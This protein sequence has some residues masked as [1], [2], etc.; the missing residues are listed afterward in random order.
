MGDAPCGGPCMVIHSAH[1]HSKGSENAC[2]REICL[3]QH[4]QKSSPSPR[5]FTFLRIGRHF[6]K[7]WTSGSQSGLCIKSPEEC[8]LKVQILRLYLRP[9]FSSVNTVDWAVLRGGGHPVHC[10]VFN[11]I[12]GLF[13]LEEALPPAC[14]PPTVTVKNGARHCWMCPGGQKLEDH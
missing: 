8:V 10:R 2:I 9:R 1:G 12:F 14:P 7:H 11:S 4:F 5:L 6:R 3:F 13:P